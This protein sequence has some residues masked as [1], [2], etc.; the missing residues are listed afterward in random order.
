MFDESRLWP[1]TVAHVP[2]AEYFVTAAFAFI[3]AHES[4]SPGTAAIGLSSPFLEVQRVAIEHVKMDVEQNG[5]LAA[6]LSTQLLE[7]AQCATAAS[8][9]RISALEILASSSDAV[10]SKLPENTFDS[11]VELRKATVIVPLQEALLPLIARLAV[12]EPDLGS[13]RIAR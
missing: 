3:L 13:S 10:E 6:D 1:A 11:L 4:S 12:C 8:E 2:S 5:P 9:C 7:L